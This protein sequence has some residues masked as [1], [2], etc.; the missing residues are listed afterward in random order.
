MIIH[1]PTPLITL[2]RA[3]GPAMLVGVV[4]LVQVLAPIGV[5]R[6]MA[7]AIA[8]P[9]GAAPHC[10]ALAQPGQ[11]SD[12]APTGHN[13]GC[14]VICSLGLGSAPALPP[15]DVVAARFAQTVIWHLVGAAAVDA[16]QFVHAQA[17]APPA[18]AAAFA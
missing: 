1:Q 15:Q 13:V 10:A 11:A 14:C 16:G 12:T 2:L 7:G 5:V 3:F 18:L 17:R 9:V 6:F 4:V 8:D